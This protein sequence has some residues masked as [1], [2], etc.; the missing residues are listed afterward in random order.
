MNKQETKIN[1][2]VGI[3]GSELYILE[4]AFKYSDG[5]KGVT[6][7]SMN[8]ITQKYIDH[9]NDIDYLE[10]DLDYLWREAVQTGKTT[11]SLREY[12]QSLIDECQFYNQLFPLDDNSFRHQT[13]KLVEELPAEQK[14]KLEK[15][16]GV[17][18]K[19]FVTWTCIGCGRCFN[20]NDKWDVIFRPD[21]IELIKEYETKDIDDKG[22]K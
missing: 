17:I 10:A 3:K 21:L 22:I 19:D 4:Y 7:Y 16:F 20:T 1:Q 11:D 5:F 9:M 6:G 14:V 12:M 18:G 8:V 15:V 2:I 13:E